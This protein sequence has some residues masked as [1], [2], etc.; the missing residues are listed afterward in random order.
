MANEILGVLDS[1]SYMQEYVGY[2]ILRIRRLVNEILSEFFC[3]L[4][5]LIFMVYLVF[6]VFLVCLVYITSDLLT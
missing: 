5:Y 6:L 4:R 3:D 1:A 2:L